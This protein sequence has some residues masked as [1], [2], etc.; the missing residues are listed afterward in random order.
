M[1]VIF[2]LSS[3]SSGVFRLNFRSRKCCLVLVQWEYGEWFRILGECHW[4]EKI[5]KSHEAFAIWKKTNLL[6]RCVDHSHWE[7][8]I[9]KGSTL[10][11]IC[12]LFRV[13]LY[14]KNQDAVKMNTSARSAFSS[15]CTD[16]PKESFCFPSSN[17][18]SLPLDF[19]VVM[20]VTNPDSCPPVRKEFI[21]SERFICFCCGEEASQSESSKGPFLW[22]IIHK[23]FSSEDP[24]Q[25]AFFRGSFAKHFSSEDHSQ[26]AFLWRIIHKRFFFGGL[27]TK[28]FSSEDHSQSAFL[29]RVIHKAL[30]FAGSFTKRVSSKDHSQS[31]RYVHVGHM[32]PS[33]RPTFLR[34]VRAELVRHR[35]LTLLRHFFVSFLAGVHAAH[36]ISTSL[37]GMVASQQL[38]GGKWILTV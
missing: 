14:K 30:F 8:K 13:L 7:R 19:P 26:N 31:T 11:P 29:Q 15:E 1:I 10:M 21:P 4:P 34:S 36:W 17:W 3:R 25:S 20:T 33:R 6:Q 5:L 23:A 35:R 18:T 2:I 12:S 16:G 27:F 38:E 22:R 9:V 37:R 28:R 24:S 32:T